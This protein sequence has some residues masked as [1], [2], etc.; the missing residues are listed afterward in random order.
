MQGNAAK[1]ARRMGTLPGYAERGGVYSS[2]SYVGEK[3]RVGKEE[4]SKETMTQ[5]EIEKKI[6]NLE[7]WVA[8]ITTSVDELHDLVV[9]IGVAGEE[10]DKRIAELAVAQQTTEKLLQ[11]LLNSRLTNGHTKSDE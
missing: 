7:A 11:R 9:K 5:Q 2:S 1:R 6:N 8:H 10:A 4:S 3:T